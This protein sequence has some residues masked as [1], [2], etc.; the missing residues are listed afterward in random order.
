M[1]GNVGTVA[2]T[3]KDDDDDDDDNDD[4][5]RQNKTKNI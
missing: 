4:D 5:E 2:N 1:N 3:Q